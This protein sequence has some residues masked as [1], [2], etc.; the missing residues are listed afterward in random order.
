MPRI[1]PPPTTAMGALVH[2]VTHSLA[3]P[4][5]PMNINFGLFPSLPG[6]SR[7]R[8]KR[9]LLAKR[10]LKEMGEWKKEVEG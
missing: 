8:A 5:Q 9:I 3:V 4:F 10:A 7:G 6:R 1:A 2:Y